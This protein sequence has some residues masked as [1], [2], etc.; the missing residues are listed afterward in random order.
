MKDLLVRWNKPGYKKVKKLK[1]LYGPT[2]MG[3]LDRANL[4]HWTDKPEEEVID[5]SS[6]VGPCQ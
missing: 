3:P 1:K 6:I 2:Q 5:S 4:N